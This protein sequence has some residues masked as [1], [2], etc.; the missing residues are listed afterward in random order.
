MPWVRT[1]SPVPE[2]SKD[3]SRDGT[4]PIFALLPLSLSAS[5]FLGLKLK[6]SLAAGSPSQ[7][8]LPVAILRIPGTGAAKAEEAT[9]LRCHFRDAA[10]AQTSSCQAIWEIHFSAPHQGGAATPARVILSLRVCLIVKNLDFNTRFGA[11][12]HIQP[13][14][15]SLCSG[16]LSRNCC[17]HCLQ[18]DF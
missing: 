18:V 4:A 8:L 17:V 13:V 15:H 14:P 2:C 12:S 16:R 1:S 7:L 11:E 9:A 10:A 3:T 5:S 6:P